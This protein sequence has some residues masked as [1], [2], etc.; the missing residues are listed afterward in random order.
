M[1]FWKLNES[2]QTYLH[3]PSS[4]VITFVNYKHIYIVYV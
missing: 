1:N 3:S 2:L 4:T